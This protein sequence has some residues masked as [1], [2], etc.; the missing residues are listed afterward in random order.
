MINT[1][2]VVDGLNHPT[3]EEHLP[4]L[5]E[6][7]LVELAPAVHVLAVPALLRPELSPTGAV[8]D[9]GTNQ[10]AGQADILLPG[11]GDVVKAGG[12]V[13]QVLLPALASKMIIRH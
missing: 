1:S 8:L 12:L 10:P 5:G 7:D 6:G 4:R 13:R 11:Q 2:V 9:V 3:S